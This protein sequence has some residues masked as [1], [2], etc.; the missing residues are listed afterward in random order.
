MKHEEMKVPTRIMTGFCNVARAAQMLDATPVDSSYKVSA[1]N[2]ERLDDALYEL[3]KEIILYNKAQLFKGRPHV[4][5]TY[6]KVGMNQ[7]KLKK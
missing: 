3:G 5:K 7:T 1:S 2:L 4:P 6:K